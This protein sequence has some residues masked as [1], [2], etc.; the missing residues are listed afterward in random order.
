M[1]EGNP[2]L[3]IKRSPVN[4]II[5]TPGTPAVPIKEWHR[6]T[7]ILASLIKSKGGK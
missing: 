7:N 6:Q 5:P 2:I 1:N 3:R 4:I